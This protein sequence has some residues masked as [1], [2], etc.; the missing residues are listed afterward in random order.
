M[1][2]FERWI[3]AGNTR[4]KRRSRLGHPWLVVFKAGKPTIP[5]DISVLKMIA[6]R[7]KKRRTTSPTPVPRS[8]YSRCAQL[9]AQF[10]VGVLFAYAT[11]GCRS[12][13]ER[14]AE[15]QR[16][17]ETHTGRLRIREASMR[18]QRQAQWSE[19]SYNSIP[20][21]ADRENQKQHRF[22]SP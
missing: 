11:S 12:G 3:Q 15:R 8:R 5:A 18:W 10:A 2:R 1:W 13:P 19:N 7:N 14:R 21:S 17:R 6:V 22:D 20:H 4:H 9:H 16:R